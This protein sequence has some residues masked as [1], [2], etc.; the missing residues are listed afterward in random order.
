MQKIPEGFIYH[1]VDQPMPMRPETRVDVVLGDGTIFENTR[2]AFWTE[3]YTNWWL[4]VRGKPEF[5]IAGWRL[6]DAPIPVVLGDLWQ[7][8]LKQWPVGVAIALFCALMWFLAGV[9][10]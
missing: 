9:V 6:A 4:G 1:A 8:A 3:G 5:S 7:E 2:A 10:S